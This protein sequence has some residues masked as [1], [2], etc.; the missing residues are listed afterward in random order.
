M[1]KILDLKEAIHLFEELADRDDLG[2]DYLEGK[3]Y[4]RAHLMCRHVQRMGLEPLKA[5]AFGSEKDHT[6]LYLQSL[7]PSLIGTSWIFHVALGLAVEMPDGNIQK[8]VF[9][10]AV[11]DGPVTVE[12][13]G[14]HLHANPK[15]VQIVGFGVAPN[16]Y[17]G[18]YIPNIGGSF[19][20]KTGVYTDEKAK[21]CVGQKGFA[22]SLPQSQRI[23][24]TSDISL[25]C[26]NDLSRQSSHH[27][28]LNEGFSK[29]NSQFC[30]IDK[31]LQGK[32]WIS[33]VLYKVQN[34]AEVAANQNAQPDC[35]VSFKLG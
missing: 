15:Q 21:E 28:S 23:V 6:R 31:K 7:E 2:L 17:E 29:V 18:D 32:T 1:T 26:S 20:E 5:W 27:E 35:A 4:A 10:P 34:Q 14:Q 22:V 33:E 3:C 12:Q 11:F 25:K 30:G 13:W 8:L 9:D 19:P 16:G 24:F